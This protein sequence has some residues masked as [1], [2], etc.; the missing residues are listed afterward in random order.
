MKESWQ[1]ADFNTID[2]WVRD[3]LKKYDI[4]GLSIAI[5]KDDQLKFA[6]GYGDGAVGGKMNR[7]LMRYTTP[8]QLAS[9]SKSIT[10][11]AI[12]RSVECYH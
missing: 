1:P 2:F 9:I 8:M 12:L 4:P 11:L 7:Q 3:F 10:S 6:A 5:S